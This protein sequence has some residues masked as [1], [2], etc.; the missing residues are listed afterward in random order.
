MGDLGNPTLVSAPCCPNQ[1]QR[2][3]AFVTRWQ[4]WVQQLRKDAHVFYFACKDARMPWSAKLV[5]ACTV[6]YVFSPVQLIPSFIPVIGFADDLVVLYLGGKLLRRLT[7]PDVLAES[8]KLAEA[9]ELRKA[10][11]QKETNSS[12]KAT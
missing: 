5:A 2:K 7:P 4:T 10:N 9:E 3:S 8:C 1:I 12:A 6:G 11:L